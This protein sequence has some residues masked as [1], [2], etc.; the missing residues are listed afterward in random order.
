MAAEIVSIV[1]TNPS[2]PAATTA[3]KFI[4]KPSPITEPCNRYLVAVLDLAGNGLPVKI[5]IDKP[6]SNAMD[7]DNFKNTIRTINT[8][9]SAV[10]KPFGNVR[11]F[12]GCS[13]SIEG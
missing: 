1:K 12:V 9:N 13:V 5:P 4:P 6:I 10:T 7:G 8:K 2:F 11:L 3:V